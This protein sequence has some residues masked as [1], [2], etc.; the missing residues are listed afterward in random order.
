MT[1]A[2]KKWLESICRNCLE[3]NGECIKDDPYIGFCAE[4]DR[5]ELL[6]MKRGGHK[7]DNPFDRSL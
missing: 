6:D 2:E 7:Y 1:E 4:N 5:D 3:A